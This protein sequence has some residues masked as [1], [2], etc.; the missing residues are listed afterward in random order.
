MNN[1]NHTAAYSLHIRFI[2]AREC[3]ASC[4]HESQ[5]F[6]ASR[7]LELGTHIAICATSII[8]SSIPGDENMVSL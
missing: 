7:V 1:Y 4:S 3:D 5:K 8:Y 6:R 2:V